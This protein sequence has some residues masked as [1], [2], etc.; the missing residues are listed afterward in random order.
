[1][2]DLVHLAYTPNH[3]SSSES[4]YTIL[5]VFLLDTKPSMGQNFTFSVECSALCDFS[6]PICSPWCSTFALPVVSEIVTES[7][8][9]CSEKSLVTK[10]LYTSNTISWAKDNYIFTFECKTLA[11]TNGDWRLDFLSHVIL[12]ILYGLSMSKNDLFYQEW[13]INMCAVELNWTKQQ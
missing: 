1:M 2:A 12:H 8:I 13:M 10:K 3:R 6:A 11:C 7:F 4:T 5:T 9:L